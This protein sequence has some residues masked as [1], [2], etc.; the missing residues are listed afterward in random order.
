MINDYEATKPMTADAT[1]ANPA[2]GETLSNDDAIS[3]LNN[4]VETCKDGQQ[5][6]KEAADG[7]E[8]SDLKS[9]FYEFSQQRSQFAGDLQGL[10]R[11][12]GGDPENSGSIAGA[13]HRGWMNIKAA[14]TG[15]DE[16]AI[17]NECERGEDI[18]KSEYK[19]ALEKSLPANIR[20]TVQNQY[21]SILAAHDRIKALRDSADNETATS[22]TSGF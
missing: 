13:I 14:V 18:A 22:A 19:S 11:D 21:S 3:C 9:L 16:H 4:L 10:V 1:Y 6:F 17:L 12:L 8:R 5:G 15:Q 7:I 20:E 2:A